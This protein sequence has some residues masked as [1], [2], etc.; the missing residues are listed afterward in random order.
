MKV[1]AEPGCPTLVK[2]GRCTIHA[3]EAEKRR[4]SRQERGYDANHDRLRAEWE[5][6]VA[7]GRVRCAR[8]RR[9]IRAGTA[10]DL[11]HSEDRK[12]YTGPE[13]ASCNRSAG[14]R[15]SHA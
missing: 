13:H 9:L 10:W 8:C 4:G 6:K 1:C 14:G 5:P 2:G 11:G 12:S 15:A 3:R 7:T